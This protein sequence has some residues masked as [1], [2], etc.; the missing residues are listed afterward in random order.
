MET[1]RHFLREISVVGALT[2]WMPVLD[3]VGTARPGA[4]QSE[5]EVLRGHFPTLRERVN[6]HRLVYLDSAATT[7]RPT[8]VLDALTDFY[9]H[10][11]ANPS[12][13]LHTLAR[14]SGL[15]IECAQD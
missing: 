7:H 3:R 9:L 14:R 1:R 8:A 13:S 4:K 15:C 2:G 12:K 11:N 10:D 6:D 5:L